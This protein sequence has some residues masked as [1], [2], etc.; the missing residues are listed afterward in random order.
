MGDLIKS[1]STKLPTKKLKLESTAEEQDELEKLKELWYSLGSNGKNMQKLYPEKWD[2]LQY[3]S[4]EYRN[5]VL[6]GRRK[7]IEKHTDIATTKFQKV[8]DKGLIIKQNPLGGE[9]VERFMGD[10]LTKPSGERYPFKIRRFP[11][12]LQVSVNPDVPAEVKKEIDLGKVLQEVLQ[13]IS[14]EFEN[15]YNQWAF[16]IIRKE[17]GGHAGITNVSGLGTLGLMPKKF[18]YQER[19]NAIF[20]D[21]ALNEH[22]KKSLQR[23]GEGSETSVIMEKAKNE[24]RK[25][26]HSRD[27]LKSM[28]ALDKRLKRLKTPDE[29]LIDVM[30]TK[31]TIIQY[32]NKIKSIY[33][34][35]RTKIMDQMEDEFKKVIEE[36]F[37]HVKVDKPLKDQERF[38][39]KK[40]TEKEYI[41]HM[42][43]NGLK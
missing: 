17:S 23:A 10:V 38:K 35:E 18:Y 36:K 2:R 13:K 26:E 4:N 7:A 20:N 22:I 21:I 5:K 37:A 14:S 31:W 42:A 33:S 19:L 24:I 40:P 9:S 27:L 25:T 1:N 41:Q 43:K 11:T 28:E 6:A 39:V 12:F 16:D 34:A 15:K 32:L 8:G 30:P 29:K 3:L